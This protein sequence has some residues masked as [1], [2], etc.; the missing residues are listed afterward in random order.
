MAGSPNILR[1]FLV[2]I[3]FKVDQTSYKDFQSKY[4]LTIESFEK[5][6]KVTAL[7]ATSVAAVGIAVIDTASKMTNLYLQSQRA[8]TSVSSLMALR[9][10]GEQAGVGADAI[11]TAVERMSSAI[12]SNSGMLSFFKQLGVQYQE[13]KGA[14]NFKNLIVQLSELNKRSPILARQFAGALGIDEQMLNTLMLNMPEFLKGM[15]DQEALLKSSG[16]SADKYAKSS[17]AAMQNWNL[18]K[19]HV[20]ILGF[21][22]G[23]HLLPHID[24]MVVFL[25]RALDFIIKIDHATHGWSTTI[26]GIVAAL[27]G[28]AA[29]LSTVASVLGIS[30]SGVA[31]AAKGGLVG[32]LLLGDA[33]LAYHDYNEGKKLYHAYKDSGSFDN[34]TAKFEGF[35]DKIY[36]DVAGH[37]TVGYGHRVRSGEDFS[38]GVTQQG[39]ANLLA[40]DT[41]AARETV[42]RLVKVALNSNQMAALTDFVFNVGSG[43]F[44]GSTLLKR[45]NAGDY[46]GASD[47]FSQW[48]HAAGSVQAGLTNRRLGEQALFNK[49][50]VNQETTIHV[51]GN[52]DPAATG[53][54]VADQQRQVNS[55]LLRNMATK[56]Q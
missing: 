17:Y 30:G 23:E 44:A 5:L 19:G 45:L 52:D 42:L 53:R 4:K 9:F 25:T 3:G 22:F 51:Y 14:D 29:T 34:W 27:G 8:G 56:V 2:A 38:G 28:V 7:A 37:A 50:V 20:E 33:A 41:A 1:E 31:A 43:A 13:G 26:G 18:I 54:E 24:K 40:M 36:N 11:A 12:R 16:I 49:P 48:N 21:M 15:S 10:G 47:Q 46:A 35:K 55:A 39:A 32:G 6:G